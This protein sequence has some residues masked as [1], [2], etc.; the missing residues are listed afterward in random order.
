MRH[1]EPEIEEQS[2]FQQEMVGVAGDADPIQQGLDRLAR[3]HQAEVLASLPRPGEKAR[4]HRC[5]DISPCHDR[6][7]M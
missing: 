6:L 3:Q 5:A 4:T 7:S 2:A 1:V